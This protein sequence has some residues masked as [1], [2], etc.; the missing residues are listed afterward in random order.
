MD[1][2]HLRAGMA[3]AALLR[4]LP[5]RDLHAPLFGP[6]REVAEAVSAWVGHSQTAPDRGWVR[7]GPQLDLLAASETQESAHDRVNTKRAG[8]L[9][10]D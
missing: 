2:P 5:P 1:G 9:R 7:I 4:G 3:P 10:R 8:K 6:L